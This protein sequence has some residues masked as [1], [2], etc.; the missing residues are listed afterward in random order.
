MPGWQAGPYSKS[1]IRSEIQK[2]KNTT[3]G[4]IVVLVSEFV[5]SEA[6][7]RKNQKFVPILG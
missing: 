5:C 3:F 6:E 7:Q 4:F 2:A 1:G